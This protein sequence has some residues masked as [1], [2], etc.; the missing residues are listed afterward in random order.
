VWTADVVRIGGVGLDEVRR[1]D[2][3]KVELFRSKSGFLEKK[4]S[5]LD[6]N[7]KYIYI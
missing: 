7:A 1:R 2:V 5:F 4:A 3:E 6:E